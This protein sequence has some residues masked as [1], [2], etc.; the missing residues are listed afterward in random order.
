MGKDHLNLDQ[1]SP[2]SMVDR[3]AKRKIDSVNH[4]KP[5]TYKTEVTT[6]KSRRMKW[7]RNDLRLVR[8]GPKCFPCEGSATSYTRTIKFNSF[9]T[10]LSRPCFLI[11]I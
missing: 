6:L 8:E 4:G 10:M 9:V 7:E 1:G 3:E 5:L 11:E 2:A